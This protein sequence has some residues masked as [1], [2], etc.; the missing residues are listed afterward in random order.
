LTTKGVDTHAN[1]RKKKDKKEGEAR[2]QKEDNE[3]PE[4]EIVLDACPA[5]GRLR[6]ARFLRGRDPLGAANDEGKGRGL[7]E[8]PRPSRS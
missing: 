2:R 6:P 3:A 8:G 1:G 4:E 5:S 7:M